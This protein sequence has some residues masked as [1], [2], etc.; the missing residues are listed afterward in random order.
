M[1]NMG[2]HASEKTLF[3]MQCSTAHIKHK[4]EFPEDW[5][6]STDTGIKDFAQ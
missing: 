3:W 2:N 1:Q 4:Q 6:Y 5:W